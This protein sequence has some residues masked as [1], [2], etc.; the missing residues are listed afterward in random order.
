M[1]EKSGK[2]VVIQGAN[3]LQAGIPLTSALGE[4]MGVPY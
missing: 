1:T 4:N 3:L 2:C